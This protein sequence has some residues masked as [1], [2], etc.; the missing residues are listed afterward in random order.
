MRGEA[1]QVEH[2]P[3]CAARSDMDLRSVFLCV[4]LE[5]LAGNCQR[6]I[7]GGYAPVPHFIKYMVSIQ[8]TERHHI[9]GGSL[10]NKYWVITAAHCNVGLKKMLVVAGDYSLSIYEGTEQ[11]TLPQLLVP[12]PQYNST[13]NNNDIMLIK[14]KAPV[15]LNSYVSVALLPRQ[16]A[17]MAAGRMC[18]VSGWGY[19]SPSTGEIPSTL[20]TVTLPIVSTHTCNSSASFNGSITENMICAG[21]SDGGKDACKGDSGGPLV[22]EGR[23]YGLVSWGNGCADPRFPG[24]YTAV[25]KYRQWIDNTIFSYYS[26]CRQD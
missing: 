8:T 7:I 6:R 26:G 1:L 21:Y 13:T 15:D 22:C 18:R 3:L 2:K 25:S 4:L 12:H 9:C 11:E 14:L 20:R 16:A 24:V 10:I 5:V 17:S 19:T 23:V